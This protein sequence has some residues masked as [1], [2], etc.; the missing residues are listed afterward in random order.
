MT[1]IVFPAA[2]RFRALAYRFQEGPR[3]AAGDGQAWVEFCI[4]DQLATLLDEQPWEEA[5]ALLVELN[6][7][8]TVDALEGLLDLADA[9][10]SARSFGSQARFYGA[11]DDY[12]G[13]LQ[14]LARRVRGAA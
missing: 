1:V 10:Q 4:E 5:L 3:P 8:L 12:A 7:A 2:A 9:V 14:T 6:P 11:V 13:A